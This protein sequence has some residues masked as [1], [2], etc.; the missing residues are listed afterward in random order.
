MACKENDD[1]LLEDEVVETIS[2]DEVIEEQIFESELVNWEEKFK[3]I[4]NNNEVASD[5]FYD[6]EIF[7]RI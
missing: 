2:T 4:A 6:R 7:N 3:R 5:K 1:P